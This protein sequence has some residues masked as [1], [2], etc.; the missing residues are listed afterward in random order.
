IV[1]VALAV[2]PG[3]AVA[4]AIS[5]PVSGHPRL[6]LTASQLPRLRSWATAT[7]PIWQRGLLPVIDNAISIYQ[8]KFAPFYTPH[9]PASGYP[10]PGD[11]QGY[12]GYLTEE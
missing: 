11:T 10:D 1:A 8:T 3:A 6:W 7:N 4:D 2:A 5:F 12:A 9:P